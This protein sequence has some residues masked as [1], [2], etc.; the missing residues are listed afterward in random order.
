MAPIQTAPAAAPA[1]RTPRTRPPRN[2]LPFFVLT[3]LAL[4]V[5]LGVS[6]G[7]WAIWQMA[8]AIGTVLP[9]HLQLHA[10]VQLLGFAGLFILGVALHALPRI[11]GAAPPSRRVLFTVLVGVGGGALLRAFGQPLA[12]W[13]AGRFLSL[14]SGVSS[15]R[16]SSRSSRGR[17][18][19]SPYAA[20]SATRSR[21][22]SSS[23]LSGPRSP[24]CSG[25]A[26]DLPRG[27]RG[28]RDSGRSRRAFLRGRALRL[29]SLVRVRLRLAD[30][31]GIPGPPA[32]HGE[33]RPACRRAS[34]DGRPPPFGRVDSR[35][36]AARLARLHARRDAVPRGSGSPLPRRGP[37]PRAVRQGSRS[38]LPSRAVRLP[39]SL[40][41]DLRRGLHR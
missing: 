24:P 26:G 10:H 18:P 34:G 41:G 39:R 21:F 19:S 35:V 17:C 5:T 3:A 20:P 22:T 40:C 11:L 14:L 9:S 16:E 12:P 36:D 31:P 25:R 13:A 28:V 4:A 8:F 33:E 38:A 2:L 15:S 29:R 30:G 23:D 1:G 6:T 27:P 32:S 7:G 37:D